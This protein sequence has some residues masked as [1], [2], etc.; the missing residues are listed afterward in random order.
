MPFIYAIASRL[1]VAFPRNFSLLNMLS[2]LLLL[3][4]LFLPVMASII[5]LLL[6]MLIQAAFF[7]V[8]HREKAGMNKMIPRLLFLCA[9]SSAIFLVLF[10]N[11]LL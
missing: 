5:V 10:Q 2:F 11:N 3:T 9:S 7:R 6:G 8:I 4:A 1:E